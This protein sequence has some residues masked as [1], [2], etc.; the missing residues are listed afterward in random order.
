MIGTWPRLSLS[1][2]L[3]LRHSKRRHRVALGDSET[4]KFARRGRSNVATSSKTWACLKLHCS[5][6]GYIAGAF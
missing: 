4:K 1:L 6:R 3:T 5:M 2:D